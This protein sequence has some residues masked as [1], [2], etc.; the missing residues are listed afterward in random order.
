M[1]PEAVSQKF[2]SSAA[3]SIGEAQARRVEEAVMNLEAVPARELAAVLR[4]G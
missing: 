3:M 1:T 4:A 2:M